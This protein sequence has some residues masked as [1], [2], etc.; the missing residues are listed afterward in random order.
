[1]YRIQLQNASKTISHLQAKRYRRL[2]PPPPLPFQP[3]MC[4]FRADIAEQLHDIMETQWQRALE[5]ISNGN[6]DDD[7]GDRYQSTKK[8]HNQRDATALSTGNDVYETPVNNRQSK[9]FEGG[10]QCDG[11]KLQSFIDMVSSTC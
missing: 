2:S 6:P 10:G 11:D 3:K 7:P 4:I 1:M 8:S 5:M 9:K